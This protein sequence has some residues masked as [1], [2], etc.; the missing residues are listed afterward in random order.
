MSD[1]QGISRYLTK[2][3]LAVLIVTALAVVG[4][5]VWHLN[6]QRSIERDFIE[7]QRD[8]VL[9]SKAAELETAFTTVYQNIRAISLLPSVR[10]IE[11]GNRLE[12]EDEDIVKLGE[13]VI[14]K[15]T[16]K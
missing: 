6:T 3:L 12:K 8:E 13:L 5:T 15:G 2:E 10:N 7:S 14:A 4:L 9:H 1:S 16:Q 11:G